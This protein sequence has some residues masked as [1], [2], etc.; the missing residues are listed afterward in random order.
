M[1][2]SYFR[3]ILHN[4]LTIHLTYCVTLCDLSFYLTLIIIHSLFLSFSLSLIHSHL[5]QSLSLSL[6]VNLLMVFLWLL[7]ILFIGPL[8]PFISQLCTSY[9]IRAMGSLSF[10][11]LSH[12]LYICL[13]LSNHSLLLP[14]V[15]IYSFIQL[16]DSL[17]APPNSTF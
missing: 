11:S 4:R 16:E 15:F 8:T 9:F 12:M 10:Y 13:F 1:Q 7:N 6:T 2:V 14:L 3:M 5:L 17:F